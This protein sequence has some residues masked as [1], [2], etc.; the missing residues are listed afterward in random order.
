MIVKKAALLAF[1]L[2]VQHLQLRGWVTGLLHQPSA[3]G[4][5]HQSL[6][7]CSVFFFYLANS[8]LLIL[9]QN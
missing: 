8:V 7:I 5:V 9:V 3:I 2:N 4:R 6:F 1:D